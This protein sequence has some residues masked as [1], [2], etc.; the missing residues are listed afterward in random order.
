VV[1][2]AGFSAA[3]ASAA[4]FSVGIFDSAAHDLYALVNDEQPFVPDEF[5]D[6]DDGCSVEIGEA[7]VTGWSNG[8]PE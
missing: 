6:D 7:V 2:D 8:N 5:V 4:G 1:F 3:I